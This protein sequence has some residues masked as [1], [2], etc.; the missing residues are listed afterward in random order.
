MTGCYIYCL[1]ATDEGVPRYVGRASDKVSY[2]FRQHITAALEKEPGPVYDWIRNV[3][4]RDA[5]IAVYT[6]QHRIVPADLEM[7]EQYWINQFSTLMNAA[8]NRPGKADS[9]VAKQIVA[10]IKA[11]LESER[12][13][14]PG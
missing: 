3:W 6:I 10:A 14:P 7:F 2:R 5:D 8:G 12:D 1:Y 11:I 9:E 13:S 4:R